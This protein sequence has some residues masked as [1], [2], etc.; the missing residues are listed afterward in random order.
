[1]TTARLA[2][3][4]TTF[5]CDCQRRHSIQPGTIVYADD[6]LEK[7]PE[8]CRAV[9]AGPCAAVLMDRRTRQVGGL[10]TAAS[11][12]MSG[13]RARPIV[14]PDKDGD[15]PVCDEATKAALAKRIGRSD[16]L[17]AAGG[18]TIND[19]AKWLAF[20]AGIP[21]VAVATA[22][23]MN[24]YTSANV[25]ATVAG[26]KMLLRARPPAAVLAR[27]TVLAE[28]P[29]ELTA[30]GLGDVLAKSVSSADWRL[31]YL[32][33]GD[34]HCQRSVEL[35][36]DV[37]PLYLRDPAT[38]ARREPDALAA[39]F[40]ALL[41]TG[42]AM[43]MAETS[44]PASGGEHLVS[45]TLDMMSAAE[46]RPHDLHGRQVG[47]ATV[48]A[49]ELYRRAMA[50]DSPRLSWPAPEADA[51]FWGPLTDAVAKQ[52]AAKAP[53]IAMA[54]DLLPCRS[55]WQELRRQII[56][57]LRPP[58]QVRDCLAAAGAACSAEDIG[59]DRPRLA[60]ALRHAHEARSRFTILDLAW[61][62][63]ILPAAADEIVQQ[64][65]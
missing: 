23:S 51:A 30:A 41:L 4:G 24:G 33:F 6:A 50:I 45:H 17:V 52:Y 46:G 20:E 19:L 5:D 55:S 8:V 43:T 49:C 2:I 37:E 39:L 13:M 35:I 15:S 64:W 38:L 65:A 60:A 11:L 54:G 56:P 58:Q 47:V 32:L 61:L 10:A 21:Y 12:A 29:Y 48:L 18:G 62:V 31:N 59:C 3:F 40:D 42:A 28:A 44:A 14:V 57:M 25:A 7:L 26:V 63:G 36:S 34:Y 16:V 1:M 27:P 22:A 9:A 53:R